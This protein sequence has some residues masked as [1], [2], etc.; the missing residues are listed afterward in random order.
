M[1]SDRDADTERFFKQLRDKYNVQCEVS[2]CADKDLSYLGMHVRVEAGK[3]VLSMRS[4][5]ET[6]LMELLEWCQHRQPLENY[7]S[8]MTLHC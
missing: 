2:F 3:A 6:M 8:V 5:V 4:Y 1:T 7:L